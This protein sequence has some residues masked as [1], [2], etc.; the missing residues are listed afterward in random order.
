MASFVQTPTVIDPGGFGVTHTYTYACTVGNTLIVMF[1][2]SSSDVTAVS[3]TGASGN[4]TPADY[5]SGLNRTYSY[6]NLPSGV[7]GF[8]YTTTG[9]HND[10][11]VIVMEADGVVAFDAGAD[12][13]GSFTNTISVDV[14]TTETDAI[15]IAYVFAAT[16]VFTPNASRTATGITST[17]LAI[18]NSA[19]LGSAG[20]KN[21]GGTFDNSVGGR[22]AWAVAYKDVGGGGG[23]ATLMGQKIFVRA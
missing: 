3:L 15:L 7:T 17:K 6:S 20:V 4:L 14:T 13:A 22:G 10:E 1:Q 21:I 2:D 11:V 18:Y 5:S 9:A 8:S 12:Q 19:A 23:G 16:G